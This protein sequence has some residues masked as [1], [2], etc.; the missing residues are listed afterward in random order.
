[1][2]APEEI[3]QQNALKGVGPNPTDRGKM[4]VKE[5]ILVERDGG[6]LSLVVVGANINDHL[7]LQTTLESIVVER[8]VPSSEHP[9]N[10]CLDKGYDNATS[11]A[12]LE[13]LGYVA[14]IKGRGEEKACLTPQEG[15]EVH[16]ARRWVV[17]RTIGW[18][19]R[20]RGI[21]VRWEKLPQNYVANLKLACAL[22]WIRRAWKAG[23][24]LLG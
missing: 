4:G 19:L 11:R 1:M 22:L 10:L 21:L 5:S 7:I 24:T 8:P 3:K 12:I 2:R 9:Q 23:S 18:L 14:H 16:P 13:A 17:E 15:D 6:P 20:W